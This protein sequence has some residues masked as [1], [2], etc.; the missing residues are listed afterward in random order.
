[1]S[2]GYRIVRTF[3]NG[4]VSTGEREIVP[5]EAEIIRG[6]FKQYLA[7]ASPKQIHLGW[8]TCTNRLTIA[9]QEVE[10]RVLRALQDKLM[11][12]G[13]SRSSAASSRRR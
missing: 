12:K 13:S 4:V 11:R 10:E 6:I 8:W 7:G 1:M 3:Q 9:R 2:F 5:E